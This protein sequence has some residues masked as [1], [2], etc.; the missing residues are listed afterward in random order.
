MK[1]TSTIKVTGMKF[2]KGTMD[3]GQAFDSTKVFVE[4]ELDTS[5]DTAMGT[6][7]AEYGLGKAEEYQKYKHLAG[8]LPFMA[9]AEIEIVTNGKTQKTVIHSL[10]PVDAVKTAAPGGKNVGA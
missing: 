7:T 2:S 10:R 9:L 4:T 5:K 3:N 1:F 8:S 6:A